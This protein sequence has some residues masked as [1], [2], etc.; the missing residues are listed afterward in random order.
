MAIADIN[1]IL[2]R[3]FRNDRISKISVNC[4]IN[5]YTF[6]ATLAKISVLVLKY[7]SR[8]GL[9]YSF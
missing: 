6:F 5:L 3:S 2:S 8:L 1:S 9:A 7:M 4:N